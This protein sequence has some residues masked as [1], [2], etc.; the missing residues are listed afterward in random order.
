MNILFLTLS[1]VYDISDHDIY[2]DLMRCFVEDGHNVYI[3]TPAE[4]KKRLAT[5]MYES[6]GCS[7]LRVKVGSQSN[8]TLIEKGFSTLCI[9][10]DYL[11]ALRKYHKGVRFDLILYATPPITVTSLIKKL[12]KKNHC[13]TYLMLKD[14]FPQNAVDLNI[15]KR[16]GLLYRYF[17]S[18][19][20]EL[21]RVSDFIGCMSPANVYYLLQNNDLPVDKVGLCPNGINPMSP[22]LV[23]K[24]KVQW[25]QEKFCIPNDRIVFVY[26][27]NLGKPQGI[28]HILDCLKA[29][30]DDK[31]IF[32]LIVGRGSEYQ[33]LKDFTEQ[34]ELKHVAIVHHLPREE[35][36]DLV[37]ISDV[38]LVFLDAKF[39]I[40]NFPSRI[41]PYMENEKP[42]AFTTDKTTDVGLI[43]EQN[44]FG[45]TSYSG[46]VSSFLEMI[47]KIKKSDLQSMGKKARRFLE[48]NYT[49]S[50]CYQI[51]MN[52]TGGGK[53][54]E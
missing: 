5:T 21:Y 32:F 41:L 14:I 38:G 22:R 10:H 2:Q 12:K 15:M 7:I 37:S 17:R 43:A 31:C 48:T 30:K 9:K 13:K 39:T 33:K 6:C 18:Q 27:G 35:Y 36:F 34:E 4:R 23:S 54:D 50:L 44:G 19:E 51:I 45:W 3:V 20:K 40:P 1:E 8:C 25:L 29:T 11:R 46:T 26:G 28:Q 24:Q 53:G 49:A 16:G 47:D 52:R 42:L